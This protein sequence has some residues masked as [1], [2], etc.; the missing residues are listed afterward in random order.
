MADL[1][2]GAEFAGYRIEGVAG[3]GGMGIVY[4]ATDLELERTVALKFIAPE[5]SRDSAFRDRFTAESRLAASLDHQNVIPIFRA[6]EHEGV[7]F[8]AMRYVDGDD[9]RS[10]IRERGRIEPREAAGI[11]A[12][13]GSA[14]DAAHASGLIHRDVKPANVLLTADDHAYLTDFGLT[15]RALGDPD[16][17]VTGELLGS[18]NYLAPEQIRAEPLG[19]GTDVY[20]LGCMLFHLLTGRVPFPLEGQEAKLW[21]HL[22]E[23]PPSAH[24]VCDDVPR[25]F[26]EVIARAMAK[27]AA[28]RYSAAGELGTAALAAAGA[29]PGSTAPTI[30][31]PQ[32]QRGGQRGSGGALLRAAMLHPF[33]LVVLAGML[34]AGA[35]LGALVVVVPLAL[36]VYAAAVAVTYHDGDVRRR[37]RERR[38]RELVAQAQDKERRIR[39]TIARATLPYEEAVQEVDRLMATM[40]EAAAHA[41][42][43][44]E[45]LEG[46]R[47]GAIARRL[48]A[49][50]AEA[51]PGK[52]PLAH[53]LG[54][55]LA[56]QRR[57][58]EQLERFYGQMEQLLVELD[59]VR[60]H[61][62]TASTAS[63]N[64]G[65]VAEE[66][67]G[68]RTEMGAVAESVSDAYEQHA[69]PNFGTGET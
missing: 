35:I 21:A 58:E 30:P 60:G 31:A 15:K 16:D 62:I 19:P 6:G 66:V 57:A 24:A 32:P 1:P 52:Q 44:Q 20:A 27:S 13:V 39:E 47:P 26:D 54:A 38:G 2:P 46:A 64:Q 33:N 41:E 28:D 25:A 10:R 29:E 3:R 63:D 40:A 7:L 61:V 65:R 56:V 50:R 17:T 69:Y 51:D 43:L 59:T 11:A 18:L 53:A 9:L 5:L 42:L 36:V 22:S 45:G 8:L 23:P 67:R 68:L 37:V 12:Q 48:D 49:V 14:L 4:R 55:Q 34:A